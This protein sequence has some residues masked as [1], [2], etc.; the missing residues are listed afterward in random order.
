MNIDLAKDRLVTHS[1]TNYLHA[2]FEGK[3]AALNILSQL[4]SQ[5]F[6]EDELLKVQQLL[7]KTHA[8]NEQLFH[9]ECLFSASW[10]TPETF[11]AQNA[12]DL[13]KAQKQ[14]LHPISAELAR[15]LSLPSLPSNDEIKRLIAYFARYAFSRDNYVRGFIDYGKAFDL[16]DMVQ[17]YEQF[18]AVTEFEVHRA[19]ELSQ[20][21]RVAEMTIEKTPTEFTGLLFAAC[22]PLPG[23]FRAHIHDINQLNAQFLGGLTFQN[24][25]FSK[26]EAEEWQLA[27][28]NPLNAGYWRAYGFTPDSAVPW[29]QV[30]VSDATV[31]LEWIGLG[32][33]AQSAEGW[34]LEGFPPP[35]AALWQRRGYQVDEALKMLQQGIS[36]PP[37]K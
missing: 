4:K 20:M 3:F 22:S 27:G 36:D 24:A 30:R 31:A 23:V 10:T 14:E 25:E 8:W 6:K 9:D 13:L 15:M 21:F 35:V 28:F 17:R 33:D 26:S 1:I 18:A 7:N 29:N 19:Q 11:E 37:H 5:E 12:L 34:L 32:F 16:L 2:S